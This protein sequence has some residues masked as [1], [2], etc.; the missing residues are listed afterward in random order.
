MSKPSS[1]NTPSVQ[2]NLTN[3]TT[4]ELGRLA[5]FELIGLKSTVE[6]QSQTLATVNAN[7]TKLVTD[8]A[9]AAQTA[10]S[11]HKRI[12]GIDDRVRD[13][14]TGAVG[15]GSSSQHFPQQPQAQ[16]S[17]SFESVLKLIVLVG[18]LVTAASLGKLAFVPGASASDDSKAISK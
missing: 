9:L 2:S 7:V 8:T 4:E 17:L 5:Y 1:G 16:N 11:A 12:D 6:Q 15:S 3:L 14:E 18:V 13:L 10:A